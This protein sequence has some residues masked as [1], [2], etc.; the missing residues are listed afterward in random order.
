[1]RNG[2]RSAWILIFLSLRSYTETLEW[3]RDFCIECPAGKMSSRMS[4]L[5]SLCSIFQFLL[6]LY[7]V[8][9]SSP[10]T[11]HSFNS[12]EKM[13]ERS[14][15]FKRTK[16]RL[17]QR[18]WDTSRGH[19]NLMLLLVYWLNIQTKYTERRKFSEI[20]SKPRPSSEIALEIKRQ[21][22][23]NISHFLSCSI[24]VISCFCWMFTF[25]L[26]L[27][28]SLIHPPKSF[29]ASRAKYLFQYI[30]SV[31]LMA[32]LCLVDVRGRIIMFIEIRNRVEDGSFYYG[33]TWRIKLNGVY[34]IYTLRKC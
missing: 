6:Y 19:W 18:R 13:K 20:M 26:A 9:L 5:S 17:V 33:D 22:R 12:E 31:K 7:P 11:A 29:K 15:T 32:R 23:A 1:M 2:K 10:S 34:F 24:N 16:K 8:M 14:D 28:L 3:M 30:W 25:L 4:I 27:S 21:K